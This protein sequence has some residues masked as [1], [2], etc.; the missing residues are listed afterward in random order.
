M[1]LESHAVDEDARSCRVTVAG[2]TTGR[3]RTTELWFVPADGGVFLMSG[4]GGLMQWCLDL[5]REEQAVLR[6]G[7]GAWQVRVAPVTDEQVRIAALGEFHD[8]YDTP[9]RDRLADWLDTA[10]V[11]RLVITRAIQD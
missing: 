4:S 6:I 11:F 3:R 10:V 5:Q 2:R 8:K 7:D 9:E 1:N